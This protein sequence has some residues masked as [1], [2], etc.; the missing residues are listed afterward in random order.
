MYSDKQS[1][2]TMEEPENKDIHS[3]DSDFFN[4]RRTEKSTFSSPNV[5]VY[6]KP[7]S[8]GKR[9]GHKKKK[10]P[11]NSHAVRYVAQKWEEPK[12]RGKNNKRN[13]WYNGILHIYSR[14]G[15]VRGGLPSCQR[16]GV[17]GVFMYL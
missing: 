8:G 6:N 17:G 7:T 16:Q 10:S 15:Q 4:G 5:H 9:E 11:G 14:L 1:C 12:C 3:I 13:T 2:F